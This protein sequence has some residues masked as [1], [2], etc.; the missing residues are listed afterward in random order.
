MLQVPKKDKYLVGREDDMKKLQSMLTHLQAIVLCGLPGMGKTSLAVHLAHAAK[1]E[2][3]TIA[4][5]N[6]TSVEGFESSVAK[7]SREVYA[8]KGKDL[9]PVLR[10]LHSESSEGL[11]DWIKQPGNKKLLIFDGL[12]DTNSDFLGKVGVLLKEE[13][14][15]GPLPSNVYCLFTSRKT[16]TRVG[17]LELDRARRFKLQRLFEKDV[18]DLLLRRSGTKLDDDEEEAAKLIALEVGGIPQLVDLVANS[19]KQ[20]E[21]NLRT[22]YEWIQEEGELILE[23]GEESIRIIY[24][25][26]IDEAATEPAL[27]EL[28]LVIACCDPPQPIPFDLF[29]IGGAGLEDCALSDALKIQKASSLSMDAGKVSAE[30]NVSTRAIAELLTTLQKFHVVHYNPMVKAVKKTVWMHAEISRRVLEKSRRDWE[31]KPQDGLKILSSLLK[32]VFEAFKTDRVDFYDSLIPHASKHLK[33]AKQYNCPADPHLLLH[34]AKFASLLGRFEK[35]KDLLL[36]CLRRSEAGG[37]SLVDLDFKAM[38]WLHL[39]AVERRLG[40]LP[41]AEELISQA[42]EVWRSQ[43]KVKSLVLAKIAHAEVFADACDFERAYEILQ[44][45]RDSMESAAEHGQSSDGDQQQLRIYDRGNYYLTIGRTCLGTK[46]D[47]EATAWFNKASELMKEGEY[48]KDLCKAYR[49]LAN[50][51]ELQEDSSCTFAK[52]RKPLSRCRKEAKNLESRHGRNHRFVAFALRE[53]AILTLHSAS[54]LPKT[55]DEEIV[56][57]LTSALSFAYESLECHVKLFGHKHQKIAKSS[58]VIADVCIALFDN[59][60]DDKASW[61]ARLALKKAIENFKSITYPKFPAVDKVIEILQAKMT[62]IESDV[63]HGFHN[64]DAGNTNS[65]SSSEQQSRSR[66]EVTVSGRVDLPVVKKREVLVSE[67]GE[68]AAELPDPQES[69]SERAKVLQLLDKVI[70][71]LQT[72]FEE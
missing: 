22:Y 10:G 39:G 2:F 52:F 63:R 54:L 46:K 64:G 5:I 3:R 26:I 37:E 23:K 35:A 40:S 50:A 44:S 14:H 31:L 32:T 59:Q 67:E 41:K 34:F 29:T 19:I 38:T 13:G 8:M 56:H 45:V 70:L 21:S 30:I 71:Y 69:V 53:V 60:F 51:R 49:S 1:D 58:H 68:I 57:R 16:L 55:K 48:K 61:C 62:K 27:Q 9:Q 4:F 6:C 42:T 15:G 33:M 25:K 72:F 18:Q 24:E 11:K 47:K 20:K 17:D 28:L 12:N 43:N 66:R 36:E 7:I 65:T